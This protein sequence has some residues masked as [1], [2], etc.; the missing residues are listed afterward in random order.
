MNRKW[1]TVLSVAATGTLFIQGCLSA[2]WQGFATD[3]WPNNRLANIAIDVLNE[4]IIG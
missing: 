4:A 1:F 2:F 3:G